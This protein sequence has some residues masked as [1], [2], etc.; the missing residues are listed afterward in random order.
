[1][2]LASAIDYSCISGWSL[3][4]EFSY[5]KPQLI[6]VAKSAFQ[7]L[8]ASGRMPQPNECEDAVILHLLSSG[9]FAALMNAGNVQND[10]IIRDMLAGCVARILLDEDWQDISS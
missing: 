3:S 9:P 8:S 6:L 4:A 2:P 7:M 5:R 1:M 10:P